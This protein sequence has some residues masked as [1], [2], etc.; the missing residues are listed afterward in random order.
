MN[1]IIKENEIDIDFLGYEFALEFEE[2]KSFYKDAI[3]FDLE[4]Y[5]YKEPKCIGVFGCCDFDEEKKVIK[6]TQYMIENSEDADKIVQ[7][8]KKYLVDMK[9]KNKK[10][11][12]TFSG[13]ND[14]T[15]INYLFKKYN[16]DLDVKEMFIQIDLQ[17]E[18]KKI[19]GVCIGLKA[20][21]GIFGVE[22]KSE[23][24]SGSNLAKTFGKIL[25]DSDYFKRMPSEKKDIILLYNE[26]DVVSLIN[27]CL[28]WN[29]I[30]EE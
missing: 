28:I 29:K 25:K 27:I 22:R 10:Y 21:E 18:Y 8:A 20:L 26:Q 6:M 11:M 14:F 15:V 30:M 5:I 2:N 17:E 13:N 4:H 23:L 24:I 7:M 3:F 1:L 12:V 16:I 9:N 19:K